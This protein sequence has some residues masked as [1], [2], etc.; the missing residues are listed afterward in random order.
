KRSTTG[1][2]RTGGRT[3]SVC[4]TPRAFPKTNSGQRTCRR[5]RN[6]YV[7]PAHKARSTSTQKS[8]PLALRG[9][10][11]PISAP[12]FFSPTSSNSG[13]L[14]GTS[15]VFRSFPLRESGVVQAEQEARSFPTRNNDVR[16]QVKHLAVSDH[17]HGGMSCETGVRGDPRSDDQGVRS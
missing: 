7:T 14:A 1:T 15:A 16:Y 12:I 17:G 11:R 5:R 8:S 3:T 9:A 13:E 10:L 6:C 4:A 2:S